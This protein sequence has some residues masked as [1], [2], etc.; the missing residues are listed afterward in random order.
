MGNHVH[1][2]L[3]D[4]KDELDL[5][6]K[7]IVGSY[8][9]YYN[10]KYDRIG[11]LFQDRYKSETVDDDEYYL[12]VLRYIHQNPVKAKITEIDKY[13]WSSYEEYIGQADIIDREFGL[14]LLGGTRSYIEFMKA[15]ET[16]K[17]NCLEM[18]ETSRIT[19]IKA[20]EIL[21]EETGMSKFNEIS[22]KE[23]AERNQILKELK[24]KGLTIKQ[25]ERLSGINRGII[26]RA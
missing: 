22:Q 13:K 2:L 10:Q 12:T 18:T 14:E 9:Y 7:K 1:L 20:K 5:I 23:K 19:D 26:Q 8:A 11:H 24:R 16:S 25:L 6:M 3:K 4:K 17:K 15:E 21:W